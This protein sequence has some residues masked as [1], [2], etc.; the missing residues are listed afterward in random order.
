[1][2]GKKM[3]VDA[4]NKRHI[5]MKTYARSKWMRKGYTIQREEK[6]GMAIFITRKQTDFK[7]KIIPEEKKDL[8]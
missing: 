7:T 3:E 2:G 6:A 4:V 5:D 1:M 8:L